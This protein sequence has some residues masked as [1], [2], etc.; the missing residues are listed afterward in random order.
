M[1]KL[2]L[3]AAMLLTTAI[4][5]KAQTVI[6]NQTGCNVD[7]VQICLDAACMPISTA[8]YSMPPFT[9]FTIPNCPAGS[10]TIYSVCWN[11]P[12][13]MGTCVTVEGSPFPGCAGGVYNAPLPPCIPCSPGGA[14]VD[15]DLAADVLRIF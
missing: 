13:C 1:K 9:N 4:A 5:S 11:E 12:G 10:I 14:I 7:V 15:Y 6:D 2:L 3:A 8:A